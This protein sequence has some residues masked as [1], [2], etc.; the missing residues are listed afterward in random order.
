MPST[1]VCIDLGN[2]SRIRIMRESD[3]EK[4]RLSETRRS[5]CRIRRMINSWVGCS[6]RAARDNASL[7]SQD[8]TNPP[9]HITR[10]YMHPYLVLRNTTSEFC[11]W[12]EQEEIKKAKEYIHIY[13]RSLSLS[14]SL[15]NWRSPRRACPPYVNVRACVALDE[16][17]WGLQNFSLSLLFFS[18]NLI[19]TRRPLYNS[20]LSLP[21]LH[22]CVCVCMCDAVTW[23]TAHMPVIFTLCVTIVWEVCVPFIFEA[24]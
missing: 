23:Q 2:S 14:F 20:L 17:S 7:I 18:D 6:R 11:T 3:E 4:E 12:R 1:H 22:L 24:I 8:M 19:H 13:L 21:F 5:V 10:T 16:T 15:I 9:V